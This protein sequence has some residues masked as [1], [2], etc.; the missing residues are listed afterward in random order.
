MIRFLYFLFIIYIGLLSAHVVFITFDYIYD[1]F[2][3]FSK[4]VFF[5]V[6]KPALYGAILLFFISKITGVGDK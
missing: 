2:F 4:D 3:V 6:M 5:D 1:G